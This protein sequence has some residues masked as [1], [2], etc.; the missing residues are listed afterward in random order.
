LVARRQTV[1]RYEEAARIM[2]L[3]TAGVPD[4]DLEKSVRALVGEQRPDG[5]WSQT[6][7]LESDAYATGTVLSTLNQNGFLKASDPAYA[8][9]VAYLLKTQ[10]PDGSWYVRSRS[11]QV[12]PYFQSAFPFE[13]DQWISVAATAL[14]VMALAPALQ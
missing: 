8:L 7:Y 10:F 1:T 14:A 13:H 4:R 11:P 2:G 9:G 3:K 5:G 12:Q 6:P